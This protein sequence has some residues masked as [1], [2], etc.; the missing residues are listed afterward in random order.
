MFQ[1][2]TSLNKIEIKTFSTDKTKDMSNMFD[3]CSSLEDSTFIESLS[4]KNVEWER[5]KKRPV[6]VLVL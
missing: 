5:I 6:R 1:K 3:G 2:C 4:T